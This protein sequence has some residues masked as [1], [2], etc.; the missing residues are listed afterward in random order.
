MW[1]YAWRE[2]CNFHFLYSRNILLIFIFLSSFYSTFDHYFFILVV[3][4]LFLLQNL[5][6]V[7]EREIYWVKWIQS[8]EIICIYR[9]LCS[10]E[11]ITNTG[12][13]EC[14]FFLSLK[15]YRSLFPK[16]LLIQ[17]KSSLQSWLQMRRKKWWR[18][19]RRILRYY[20][21]SSMG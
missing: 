7:F 6:L 9:N 1:S 2:L 10:M 21:L 8:Q 12:A 15:T 20:L 16:V 18:T 3:H 14:R 13:F 5:Q 11:T 4:Y 17:M 19:I